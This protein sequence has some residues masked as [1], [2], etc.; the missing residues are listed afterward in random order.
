VAF[1]HPQQ[2]E[3]LVLVARPCGFSCAVGEH[4]IE[5]SDHQLRSFGRRPV[6]IG[7]RT[8]RMLLLDWRQDLRQNDRMMF[9][10]TFYLSLQQKPTSGSEFDAKGRT[11]TA[12][13]ETLVN[14]FYCTKE[15]HI[16]QLRKNLNLW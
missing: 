1:L 3:T 4:H 16:A 9:G 7:R 6:R 15:I 13:L 11:E 12:Q 5:G 10:H 2:A 8:Y 14:C